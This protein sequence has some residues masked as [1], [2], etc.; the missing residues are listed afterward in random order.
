MRKIIF[1][2]GIHDITA[3]NKKL[4]SF[5]EQEGF[6]V[7]YFLLFYSVYDTEKQKYLAQIIS[8]SIKEDLEDVSI[9]GHSF[10][11]IIAYSLDDEVYKKI[12]TIVTVSSP[13]RLRYK[14]FKSILS[15]LNYKERVVSS[16][17]SVGMLYDFVVRFHHAGRSASA[18]D[19]IL[20]GFHESL[21][22]N[23][24]IM[25]KVISYL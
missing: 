12:K 10:G 22:R 8:E 5:L 20:P 9:L 25:K 24:I 17:I 14:W 11:G 21:L 19:I 4:F 2:Q 18:P 7:K 6:E 3:K 23:K 16:Q 15:K 1:I 13:H